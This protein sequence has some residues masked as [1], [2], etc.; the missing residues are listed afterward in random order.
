MNVV[1]ILLWSS[2]IGVSIA[3]FIQLFLIEGGSEEHIKAGKTI[4][5]F[6]TVILVA[7]I[8]RGAQQ[9]TMSTSYAIHLLSGGPFFASLFGTGFLGWK[10]KRNQRFALW[11]KN[12]GR[13]TGVL[14]ILTLFFG[15][16]ARFSH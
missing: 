7:V 2:S 4:M 5:V 9:E 3:L 1:N 12:F 16:L 10:T 8:I 13:A 11:H 14:L 6:G 15:L